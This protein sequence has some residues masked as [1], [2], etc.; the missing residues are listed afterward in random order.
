MT[1]IPATK[2]QQIEFIKEHRAESE[3]DAKL[4]NI[5]PLIPLAEWALESG[6]GLNYPA[7]S[8]N[9][10]G[11]TDAKGNLYSFRS[12]AEMDKW[13]LGSMVADN[14][15]IKSRE[16]TPQ[17][18]VAEIFDH[19]KY[20][21]VNPNYHVEVQDCLNQIEALLPEID[22]S[23]QTAQPPVQAQAA[24]PTQTV[25]VS[26]HELP[27]LVSLEWADGFKISI[28]KSA[29]EAALKN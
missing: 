18:T 19:T 12:W 20:N 25:K 15:L 26:P 1:I 2:E 27:D 11:M 7:G 23:Q 4:L 22:K 17:S 24:Q 10:C 13:Y 16:A 28:P 8:H 29:I 21:T 14:P 3:N 5:A 9:I 6:W